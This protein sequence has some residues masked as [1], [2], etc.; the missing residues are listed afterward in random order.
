MITFQCLE[1]DSDLEVDDAPPL[2]YKIHC[3]YCGAIF[4][5]VA[6][7]PLEV[8]WADDED[9]G[10]DD[11]DDLLDIALDDDVLGDD[12]LDDDV[13]GDDVLDDDVLAESDGAPHRP[14]ASSRPKTIKANATVLDDEL[15]DTVADDL[16][17]V[18]DDDLDDDD[19]EDDWDFGDEDE[20][21]DDWD[22]GDEDED[23]DDWDF[24][25]E[26]EDSRWT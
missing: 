22:F 3:A 24:D 14:G 15:D 16:S 17:D 10:R 6:V 19:E 20:D 5:V 9:P 12:V 21:D 2:G 18:L 26:D 7:D 23:D 1:C 25:D 4:E 8:D 13:L 11:A